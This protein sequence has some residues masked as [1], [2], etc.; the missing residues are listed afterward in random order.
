MITN[1]TLLIF[2]VNKDTDGGRIALSLFG[3]RGT[4]LLKSA[5]F[6]A[7]C[8]IGLFGFDEARILIVYAMFTTLTQRELEAPVQN[9]VDEIDEGRA[10]LGFMT[11]MLVTLTLL[12]MP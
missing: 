11:A 3:R 5:T 4:Y 2:I 10:L 9:E 6:F 1:L 8:V 12:P 7:I